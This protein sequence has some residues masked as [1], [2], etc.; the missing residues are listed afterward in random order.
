MKLRELAKKGVSLRFVNKGDE[1]VFYKEYSLQGGGL[2]NRRSGDLSNYKGVELFI[3][4]EDNKMYYNEAYRD[5]DM[6]YG[7]SFWDK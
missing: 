1:D 3:D 2:L 7:C 5:F 6:N 4:D